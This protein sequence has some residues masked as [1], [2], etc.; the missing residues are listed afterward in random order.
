VKGVGGVYAGLAGHGSS[1]HENSLNV[2]ISIT[3][4]SFYLR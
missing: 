4:P 3:S 1:W 2:N